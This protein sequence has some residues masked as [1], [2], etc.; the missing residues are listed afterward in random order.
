MV[1]PRV[2]GRGLPACQATHGISAGEVLPGAG[3][4]LQPLV[5]ARAPS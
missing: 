1:G 2:R 3:S 4:L 5:A